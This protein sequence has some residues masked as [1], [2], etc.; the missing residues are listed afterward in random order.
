M[1]VGIHIGDVIHEEG[2][3]YGDAV[4][5][6]SRIEPLAEGGGVCV[7][8]QAYDQVRNKVP[9]RFSRLATRELKNVSVPIEV[10]R[11]E[12]LEKGAE[13]SPVETGARRR[14]VVLPFANMS[15]DHRDEY[16]SD[17]MTEEL[18]STLSKIPEIDVISRTSV[19]QY[20]KSPKPIKEVFR[21][22][23]AGTVLEG[24]VRKADSKLRVTV[25]MIDA[26]RDIHLWAESYD[27][28][29]KDVFAIQS[30]ITR[31]VVDALK[32]KI[33]PG[34][35]AKL[36][37]MPTTNT[38]AYTLYPKG[39]YHWNRRGLEDLK[40]ALGYFGGAVKEDPGFALGYV[41]LAD[42]DEVLTTRFGMDV[43]ENRRRAKAMLAKALK[44]D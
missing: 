14:L 40:Q 33:L 2:D 36:E 38:G 26:E 27:R 37:G 30:D 4:N 16:F 19:M 25:Q 12:S 44:L 35:N 18:I 29:L 13:E 10:Y 11:L 17:G 31:Q 28:D 42:C 8:Q 7:S 6:A 22:L 32:L 24:S 34:V 43:V 3:V 9:F 23:R 5:I 1:R 21:E 20:K 39:R 15:P 41:L